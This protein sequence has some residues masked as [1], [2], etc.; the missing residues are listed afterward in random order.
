MF[1]VTPV[2]KPVLFVGNS[3]SKTYM[4]LTNS[5]SVMEVNGNPSLFLCLRGQIYFNFLYD[6]NV[7]L[8]QKIIGKYGFQDT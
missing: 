4:S 3:N 8:P 2:Y 6:I 5:V 7:I 1:S